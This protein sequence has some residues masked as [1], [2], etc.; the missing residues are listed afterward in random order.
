MSEQDDQPNGATR[1]DAGGPFSGLEG[2]EDLLP[3]A[4][5]ADL[6]TLETAE[7]R[8][9]RARC[10]AAEEGVS[11]ARRVLQGRLDILRARLG[12]LGE[13]QAEALRNALPAILADQGHVTDPLQARATRVRVPADAERYTAV[14]DAVLAEEDLDSLDQAVLADLDRVIERLGGVE[15]ELS[16]R[17]RELFTRIDA[18]R[19][20]LVAR[21]KDGRADVRELLA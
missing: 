15:Q 17:R 11:Y 9:L 4:Q 10:E 8:E 12:D 19:A 5:L 3:Q 2:P 6:S 1:P 20:E 13:D 7:L 14:V 16:R 21:Y 18:V